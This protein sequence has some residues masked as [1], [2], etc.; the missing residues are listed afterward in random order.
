MKIGRTRRLGAG[1]SFTLMVA[2][3]IMAPPARPAEPAI[4]FADALDEAAISVPRLDGVT[5]YSLLIG[6]GDINALVYSDS[7]NLVLR[8][9]KN[10][11]WD[12][13]LDTSDDPPLL[14]IKRI[15][16]LARGDWLKDGS[17]G[18]G[19]LDPDGKPHQGGDSW[20]R[21]YPCPVPCGIVRLG[22]RPSRPSWRRV[23]AEGTHN[24]WERQG[25]AAVMSIEG[26]PGASNGFRLGPIEFS[27]DDYTTLTITLSGT[28][29]ARYFV[30]IGGPEVSDLFASTWIETPTGSE[31][32][33][34]GLPAGKQADH[35]ILYTWTEDGKRA[36]N[37][38]EAVSVAGPKGKMD[39]DV[40]RLEEPTASAR[41]DLRRAAA[42]VKGTR[43]GP[44]GG[45]IRALAHCNVFLIDTPTTASLGPSRSPAIPSPTVGRRDGVD[46]IHQVL[47]N[48][49]DWPG[50]RFAVALAQSGPRKAV[51][52]VTS[53][54]SLDE[55]S[56]A[57]RLARVTVRSSRARLVREHEMEWFR[58]WVA[59]GI[60]IEDD[61]LSSLWYRNLYFLRC[62]SKP[63][64]Q[65]VGL[66]AGLVH[67][68]LPA[69][70]GG[71]TTNYNA[72]Q[73]F[74]TSFPTNHLELNEPYEQ[75]VSEYLP[76]ARWLCRQLYDCEGAYYPHNLF[77]FEPAHPELCRSRLGRQQFYVTWSY[78][79]GVSGFTVQNL[80]LRYKY[81]PDRQYLEEVAYPA[82]RDVATFYANFIGQCEEGE[83]GK[84]ILAPSVSPEHWGW[85]HQ[86]ERNRNGAFDVA[87]A[88]YTLEAAIEGATTLA[89]DQDLVE[90]FRQALDR[91]PSYPT[92]KTD[93]PIV[94][95]VE[96]APPTT[97]NIAVPA[98]PVFPGNAVTWW[99]SEEEKKLFART[100]EQIRWNGNNSSIILAVARARLSMPDTISWL[101]EEMQA[102]QRPN[103]T[104]TLNRLGNGINDY[105]H[106]TE[107]FAAS[108]AVS[109]L[110]MQ[111]V[112]DIIR[113]FP[114][115]PKD[116]DA[117][118]RNLRAQGGFLVSAQQKN[119]EATGIEVTATADA[120]LR[121]LSPWPGIQRRTGP[122]SRPVSL[123][124]DGRN[125]IEVAMRSGERL[126]LEKAG[127]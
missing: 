82:V 11:V 6:N 34:F 5:D 33:S 122:G 9:T 49:A 27:T 66:Y 12:A 13:R 119:G 77:N 94:V 95:D 110:L 15:K 24:G 99:S 40:A 3:S 50:M 107:Q 81:K 37:R 45:E 76:R 101:R 114:A 67:D 52:I 16:E 74:W 2:T 90:R 60:D 100:I 31:E 39:I 23:R 86:F 102:R 57:I 79:I 43:D 87:F 106:Y 25:G 7:G 124:R 105:G 113:V 88:K 1:A 26:C 63:G 64:V 21:P 8:L 65:C 73:T 91:L 47:P 112:G 127:D 59:S 75:L 48:D 104:I 70:H 38:F 69:W 4:P 98:V 68:G 35:L 78:T 20:S 10:D 22:D 36:E 44:V 92:T 85:T 111:S 97:Y 62:V 46:F 71:H 56:E 42:H 115:W 109:E 126:L 125:V 96:D 53:H 83:G 55:V 19:W 29:N 117:R 123:P 51:A 89:R 120:T 30:A 108:M 61:Y 18:G 14:P 41:L 121:L 54:E 93:P 80:W 58:F 116:K 17:F 84:V 118:F 103:G 72:E 32:K 28:E